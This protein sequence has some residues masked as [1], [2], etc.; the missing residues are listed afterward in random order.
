MTQTCK[1]KELEPYWEGEDAENSV[2]QQEQQDADA[3]F[4]LGYTESKVP[5]GPHKSLI[6][7]KKTDGNKQGFHKGATYSHNQKEIQ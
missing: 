7:V 3:K 2:G 1:C 4:V 6:C 5:S